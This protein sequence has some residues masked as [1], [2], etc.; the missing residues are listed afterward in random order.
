MLHQA[1]NVAHTSQA[2]G[3]MSLIAS[4]VRELTPWRT[5]PAVLDVQ[6]RFI[7]LLTR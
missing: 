3:A 4:A 1:I 7:E 5:V 6:D 2:G